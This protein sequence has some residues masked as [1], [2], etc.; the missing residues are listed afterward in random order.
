MIEIDGQPWFVAP[1]ACKALGLAHHEKN[2]YAR[3][4]AKL[5][6]DQIT[7]L[8][9]VGVTHRWRGS[10]AAKLVS[11]SGLHKLI[12]RSDKREAHQFQDWIARE[13]FPSISTLQHPS[14]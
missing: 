11:E 9:D 3:H 10:S 5:S 2:G 4:L 7:H 8:S 12:M 14:L 1:D 13:V 6:P